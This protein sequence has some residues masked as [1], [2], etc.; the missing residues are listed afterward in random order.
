LVDV[1]EA[2]GGDGPSPHAL[3]LEQ[4]VEGAGRAV[5]D[6]RAP[7]A[8]ELARQVPADAVHDG[9]RLGRIGEIFADGDEPAALLVESGH[10][11]KGA[12][13]VDADAQ[14]HGALL[15]PRR[16]A[17]APASTARSSVNAT[18]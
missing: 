1:A 11:G 17:V 14:S 15:P 4:R 7:I 3:A 10:V 16:L 18:P 5:Q 12:A 9:R 8:A 6:Q 2:A 13:D